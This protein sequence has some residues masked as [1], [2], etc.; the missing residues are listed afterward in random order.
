VR[1][2]PDHLRQRASLMQRS[3]S[4]ACG[5]GGRPTARR[6]DGRRVRADGVARRLDQRPTGWGRRVGGGRAGGVR[7]RDWMRVGWPC[8]TSARAGTAQEIGWALRRFIPARG[9]TP[10]PGA[11]WERAASFP[12]VGPVL[13]LWSGGLLELGEDVVGAM[14]DLARNGEGG[15]LPV[16]A[17]LNVE[18]EVVGASIMGLQSQLLDAEEWVV[19]VEL[20]PPRGRIWSACSTSQRGSPSRAWCTR[21]TSTTTRWRALG[22]PPSWPR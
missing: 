2:C 3:P 16:A 4:R 13:A 20:D 21:S 10:V 15:A 7:W 1:I 19:S 6:G 5:P 14:G 9:S 12:S 8:P 17:P 11:V 18:V 22:C